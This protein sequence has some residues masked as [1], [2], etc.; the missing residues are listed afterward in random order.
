MH[1]F[2]VIN[3]FRQL[4]RQVGAEFYVVGGALRDGFLGLPIKD[5]DFIARGVPLEELKLRLAQ[6]GRAEEIGDRFPVLSFTP[7]GLFGDTYEIALPRVEHSDGAGTKGFRVEVD[8]L[9][10]VETDLRRRDFT[11]NAQAYNV[12][13][14]ETLDPYNSLHDLTSGVVKILH[15]ASFTDD[16]LRLLRMLRFVAKLDFTVSRDTEQAARDA[17]PL[18]GDRREVPGERIKDEL[19]KIV[20]QP[21]AAKAFRL[22]R[23]LGLLA[24]FL[25]EVQEGVGVEQNHYHA[26]TVDEHCFNVL[27]KTETDEWEVK[28]ASLLHDVGKP[29]VKWIGP[30]GIPHFYW[31][32]ASGGNPAKPYAPG[33]EPRIA[34]AHEEVGADMTRDLLTRLRFSKDQVERISG[35][36]REHMFV[37]HPKA[38]RASAR[39]LLQRLNRLP[40]PLEDNVT[41]LFAIRYG[42]TSGG[43]VFDDESIEAESLDEALAIDRRFEAIVSEELAAQ[44]AMTVKDLAIGGRALM[45]LGLVGPEIGEMQKDLLELVLDHPEMNTVN[46][47]TVFTKIRIDTDAAL[48]ASFI[49]AKDKT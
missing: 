34:G 30:D 24:H 21:H 16:P 2:R 18:L 20:Q 19:I 10:D 15:P 23:D 6:H 33:G 7:S 17:A 43:K 31:N 27:D 36:V 8:H 26:Y 9:L 4:G 12:E 5:Y 40:G 39:R 28:L 48:R 38:S 13:T 32:K 11:I 44:T 46:S 29:A 49:T 14:G 42:D 47:L 25:P 22:A 1:T 35:L 3:Y 37:R 45:E 41:A